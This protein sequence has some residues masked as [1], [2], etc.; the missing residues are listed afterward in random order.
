M[1]DIERLNGY[2]KWIG[3]LPVER[4]TIATKILDDLW[5]RMIAC[6]AS[7]SGHGNWAG[8]L[9][10]HSLLVTYYT[11][12]F[13]DIIAQTKPNFCDKDSAIFVALFHDLG[14]IGSFKSPYY[15]A[16]VPQWKKTRYGATFD[17]IENRVDNMHELMSLQWMCHYGVRLTDSETQAIY[18]HAG[19]YNK[20][21]EY[22][23][24][25]DPLMLLVH[26]ADNTCTKIF[27]I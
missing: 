4:K 12:L 21:S 18:H 11:Q 20:A 15:T 10:D 22:I 26:M 6:P 5:P 8:G 27:N 1:T 13:Y 7:T 23:Y 16:D 17:K 9:V 14:K 19:R 24:K 2:K 3:N 25:E